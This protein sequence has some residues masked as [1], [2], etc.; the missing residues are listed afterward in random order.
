M[1]APK[2]VVLDGYTLNPGD[3]SWEELKELGEVELYD[4]TP[5]D[6]VVE[7]SRDADV[8]LTNK[9]PLSA[10]T[11]E[12]LP[13]LRYIGVTATGYNV[14]DVKAARRRGVV[15]TNVPTYGTKSVAQFTFALLLELCHRVQRHADAVRDGEWSRRKDF[16]FF[17]TDQMELDGKTLGVIGLGRIGS[18]VAAIGRAFG[19]RVVAA[20]GMPGAASFAR[21]GARTAGKAGIAAPE[22]AG[23]ATP[24]AAGEVP[25]VPLHEL[26][27]TADVVSLHCPLTPATAG[28][29]RKETLALM[30]PTALLVNTA[31]GGL[32]V[33]EDL[34]AALNEGRIAG[35]ALDVI[36][37]EP[38]DPSNPLLTAKNCIITPHMAWTTKEARRRLLEASIE[39]VRCFLQGKPVNVV[40]PQA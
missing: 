35:A 22:N 11:L 21:S 3:L 29:M 9:V 2:I 17:V 15:V 5:A 24:G 8:V 30:K 6:S 36:S 14:V 18:Q 26:L 19:M 1:T 7:R 33:D 28:L 20:G 31:R 27:K 23:A 38:P 34:A 32:V 12:K 16:S 13:K 40:E 37:T 39:N 4:R 10:E 25:R